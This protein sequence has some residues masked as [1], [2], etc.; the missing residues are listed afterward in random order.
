MPTKKLKQI[1]MGAILIAGMANA[2]AEQ[3][4]GLN[5]HPAAIFTFAEKGKGVKG[6]GAIVTDLLFA[7]LSMRPNLLLVDREELEKTLQEQG[8]SLS[9]AV[10]PDQAVQVGQLTGAKIL[11][12]GSVLEAGRKIYVIGKIIG[13]ETSRVLGVSVKGPISDDVDVLVPKLAEKIGD[14]LEKRAGELVAKPKQHDDLVA[15]LKKTLGK[16]KRPKVYIK[17][18]ERHIGRSV[19]DPAAQTE[20]VLFCTETGFDVIDADAGEKRQADIVI[21]G[22]AFSE[23]LTTRG[24]ISSAKARL[25]V[26]A[27]DPRTNEV[28][29]VDR[30]TAVALDVGELNAGKS[31]LQR[32]AAQISMRLLP[33][34]VK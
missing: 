3:P 27:I 29:A 6:Q 30:Q 12:T 5:V 7:E 33:K 1:I 26:K 20:L 10:N 8:L 21:K 14:L 24:G 15:E 22:E 19:I 32:A 16:G 28:I 9:G 31:A 34:L 4:K 13:T 2:K 17:I 23:F 11:I 25:E 18:A